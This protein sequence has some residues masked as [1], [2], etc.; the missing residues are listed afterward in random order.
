MKQ[1]FILKGLSASKSFTCYTM[2]GKE[3]IFWVKSNITEDTYDRL[4]NIAKNS[5]DFWKLNW[6]AEIKHEG[7]YDDGT[8]KN[9]ILVSIRIAI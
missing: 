3:S 7:L 8:P 5:H 4:F 1:D 6:I 9:P 2:D